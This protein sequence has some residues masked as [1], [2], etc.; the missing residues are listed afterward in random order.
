VILSATINQIAPLLIQRTGCD[1][2]ASRA[3]LTALLA[4]YKPETNEEFTLAAD[5]VHYRFLAV[6]NMARSVE[7]NLPLTK[8]LRLRG[9]AVSLSREAHKTQRKLDK[10]QFTRTRA[11]P[12][13][14]AQPQLALPP[15][16]MP[17]EPAPTE[18]APAE[19][20]KTEP[21]Q[22][23]P[24]MA[25][26]AA[27]LPVPTEVA[28]N[29]P[30]PPPTQ[31]ELATLAKARDMLKAMNPAKPGNQGG[32]AYAQQLRKR[33]LTQTIKQN[34]ARCAAETARRA[35]VHTA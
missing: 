27:T 1:E 23:A 11:V 35:A 14:E 15:A 9:S 17:N 5:I 10:L 22:I 7:P 12:E 28:S 6:D 32:H 34:A 16:V 30:N 29:Q 25:D 21:A 3:A 20:A 33:I 19:P 26:P 8:V 31:E 2:H 13:P 4:D 18:A 24:T